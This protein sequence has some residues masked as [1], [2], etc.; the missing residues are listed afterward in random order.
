M[1]LKGV[2][3]KKADIFSTDVFLKVNFPPYIFEADLFAT[4]NDK[5]SSATVGDGSVVFTL[6]KSSAGIWGQLLATG[7]KD[8]IHARRLASLDRAR[9]REQAD[10]VTKET[11]KHEAERAA[12]R[13]QMELEQKERER[14]Q[15]LKDEEKKKVSAEMMNM[16]VADKSAKSLLV[17]ETR[18]VRNNGK[19]NIKFTPR[20]FPTPSR[21]SYAQDEEEWLAKQ[22]A[23]RKAVHEA[24]SKEG[25]DIEH[26]PLWYKD[27]GNEFFKAENF[28]AAINAF[29]AAISLDPSQAILYSNRA[30]CHLKM[31]DPS[32]CAHDSTKAL[33]LLTP[34]VPANAKSRLLAYTRRAAAMT[35]LG[36][37]AMALLDFEE[38]LK[39]DPNNDSLLAD[40]SRIRREHPDVDA[41]AALHASNFLD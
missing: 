2:N 14:V 36:N 5:T 17:K 23:A 28:P 33:S 41:E 40:I 32:A 22:D 15:Q 3:P 6:Q 39:L 10:Q 13:K 20:A 8:E 30:A 24:K 19:I 12:L 16:A 18:P 25:G 21:E 1:P 31:N 38:A 11:E 4:V 26:D 7:S 29:T 37:H 34:P 27:R 9:E 35:S